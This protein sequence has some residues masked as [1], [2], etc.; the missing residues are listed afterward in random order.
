MPATS[1]DGLK[2]FSWRNNFCFGDGR[3]TS[4]LRPSP[5]CNSQTE[6]SYYQNLVTFKISNYQL[7]LRSKLLLSKTIYKNSSRRKIASTKQKIVT[8]KTAINSKDSY[9][10]K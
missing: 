5:E 6:F 4:N 8:I 2:L 3:H 1:E 10:Q 7:E 9:F